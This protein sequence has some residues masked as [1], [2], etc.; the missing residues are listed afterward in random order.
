MKSGMN[1]LAF[2][3]SVWGLYSRCRKYR[4]CS[5]K[6]SQDI[7]QIPNCIHVRINSKHASGH[8]PCHIGLCQYREDT[9]EKGNRAGSY[10]KKWDRVVW[11]RSHHSIS[12]NLV[13]EGRFQLPLHKKQPA[14]MLISFLFLFPKQKNTHRQCCAFGKGFQHQCG[15]CHH[16]FTKHRTMVSAAVTI[17][18]TLT[19]PTVNQINSLIFSP[20]YSY[21]NN[22][23]TLR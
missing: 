22:W 19:N 12:L 1:N 7:L 13:Q 16:H 18:S 4:M 17:N 10:Q 2:P 3:E 6:T 9:T 20:L 8:F 15:E 23:L 21:Y 5:W 14:W 11:E